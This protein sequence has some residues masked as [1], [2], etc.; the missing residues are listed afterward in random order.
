[1]KSLTISTRGWLGK[2]GGQAGTWGRQGRWLGHRMEGGLALGV[3]DLSSVLRW[4]ICLTL[5]PALPC[6]PRGG[7][8][9]VN[10]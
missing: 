7:I 4:L 1:M 9:N 2:E 5:V 6:G 8:T 10:C 3:V